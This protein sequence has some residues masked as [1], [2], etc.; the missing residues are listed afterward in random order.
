[1]PSVVSCVDNRSSQDQ[2]LRHL[3][4]Q[5][6]FLS[7]SLSSHQES[8]G[9]SGAERSSVPE[10]GGGAIYGTVYAALGKEMCL[11]VCAPKY[12]GTSAC[13]RSIFNMVLLKLMVFVR[14]SDSSGI[15]HAGLKVVITGSSYSMRSPAHARTDSW[16]VWLELSITFRPVRR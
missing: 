6:S 4:V 13:I 14:R 10:E 9:F 3:V 8:P 5:Q 7:R 2:R 11:R 1:M 12:C 16:R 15:I